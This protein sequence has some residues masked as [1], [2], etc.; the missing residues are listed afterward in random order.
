MTDEQLKRVAS[1][2]AGVRVLH[3]GDCIGADAEAYAMATDRSIRVIGHPPLVARKRAHLAYDEERPPLDYLTRN[4]AI[5]TE[6][7]DGLI[8]APDGWVEK[9]R[10]G[11][12]STVRKAF[13][14]GRR[15]WVVRPDG[16]VVEENVA[17]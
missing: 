12:W 9:K 1:L 5:A 2:L 6:G 14:L 7:V 8:A 11:T 15:I 3:L 10:S 4:L 13:R 16:S 17:P